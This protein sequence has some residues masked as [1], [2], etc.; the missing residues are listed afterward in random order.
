VYGA[1][2]HAAYYTGLIG[3]WPCYPRLTVG[4]GRDE[5]DVAA[6]L[7]RRGIDY[8]RDHAGRAPAVVAVR[9][10]RTFDLWAPRGATRLEAQIGDRDLAVYRAGV[11][12]YYLLA[13]LALAGVV[14]LRRRRRP[15]ALLVCPLAVAVAVTVLGYGTPRF[16]APAEIPLVV[17][18]SVALVAGAGRAGQRPRAA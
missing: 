14:L 13:P 2:C 9:L 15:V 6:R 12:V 7:R 1:N 3:S 10:L 5:A 16:R 11:L 18:A 17:L 4:P 8:A